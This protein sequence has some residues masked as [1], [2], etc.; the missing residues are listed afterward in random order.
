MPPLAP[1]N[2]RTVLIR[3]AEGDES[4][5]DLLYNYYQPKLF[6]YIHP[7][8]GKSKEETEEILQ[9][10]FVKLWIRKE[11]LPA[12]KSF[13][14]Y[15]FRMTRNQLLDNK[16]KKK[17]LPA[18]MQV[19][20]EQSDDALTAVEKML[21]QE[22]TEAAKEAILQLPEQRR[23]IFLMRYQKDMTLDEI[24]ADLHIAKTTTKKQLYAAIKR[25]RVYLKEKGGWPAILMVIILKY[26]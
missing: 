26:L 5:F 3:L 24:A 8:T 17:K 13:P 9:E 6:L 20:P 14:Q 4:A 22:Y 16:A 12:V 11:S 19:L 23:K 18:S 7:F 21:L 15:L 1:D 10:V 25:V 2:E